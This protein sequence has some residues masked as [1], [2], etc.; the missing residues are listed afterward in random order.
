MTKQI[1]LNDH[2]IRQAIAA[3]INDSYGDKRD[4]SWADVKSFFFDSSGQ[5]VAQL[6]KEL[7]EEEDKL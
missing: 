2:D 4:F 3:F 7:P 1:I 6:N 5:I